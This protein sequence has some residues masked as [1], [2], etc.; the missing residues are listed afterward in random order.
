MTGG[1]M[2]AVGTGPT[3][4]GTPPV[5][6]TPPSAGVERVQHSFELSCDETQGA[7]H[8]EV[9]WGQNHFRLER[10]TEVLCADDPNITGQQP[11][12]GFDTIHGTG[13]GALNGEAGATIAFTFSDAGEPGRDDWAQI[14]I[15]DADGDIVLYVFG[16]LEGGNHQAHDGCPTSTPGVT[17]TPT[18]TPTATRTTAP[19]P[20]VG[21]TLTATPAATGIPSATPSAAGTSTPAPPTETPTASPTP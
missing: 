14:T 20:T 1:G 5:T 4:T 10:I 18:P 7:N 19:P 3:P 11:R 8:L 12:T 2:I 15:H 17:R 21:T 9:R 16:T 13:S 6:G